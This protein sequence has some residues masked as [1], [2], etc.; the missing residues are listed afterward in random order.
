MPERDVVVATLQTKRVDRAAE[1]GEQ[2]AEEHGQRDRPPPGDSGERG[3]AGAEPDGADLVAEDGAIEQEPDDD[4]G[5][6]RDQDAGMQPGSLDETRERG[7]VD[8]GLRR[9]QSRG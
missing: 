4:R 7:V 3:R 6:E 1:S 5:R 9:L 2:A 8:R